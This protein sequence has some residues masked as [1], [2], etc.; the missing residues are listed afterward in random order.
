[1]LPRDEDDPE[2]VIGLVGPIGCNIH[3]VQHEILIVLRSLDYDCHVV[4]LSQG[5][6]DLLEKR[7]ESAII[8]TL[9]QKIEGGNN[10]RKLYDRNEVLA[11]WAMTKIHYFRKHLLET[12]SKASGRVAY[13]VRQLKRTEEIN[14]MMKVYGNRF[15]VVSIVESTS[16]R[17]NNLR[18]LLYR[19]NI[20]QSPYQVT[21]EAQELMK[22]DEDEED[23]E[24][25]QRLID[26]FHFGDVFIDAR[27]NEAIEQSTKR[28]FQALFGKTDISPTR[29]EFGVYMAKSVSLRSADL[30]RQ[31]GAAIFSPDGNIV[32][33]GCNENP[34][35]FGGTYW[36]EDDPKHRDI[37]RG[38]E[39][40]RIE[41]ARIVYDFL[42]VLHKDKLFREGFSPDSILQNKTYRHNIENSLIGEITEYGRMVHAEMNALAD[43][44]RLG[45]SVCGA[46][47]YVTTFPCH[48]CAKHIIASG[49]SRVVYIE[50]YPKSRTS[51][52]YEYA[53]DSN[54]GSRDRVLFE[55]FSGI[56]PNRFFD[57]FNK[58]ERVDRETR[59][60][61]EY[62]QNCRTP[63]I[64]RTE[65]DYTVR[66]VFAIYQN[67]GAEELPE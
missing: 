29:D 21:Q 6:S 14:L 5:I 24:N 25:G 35:P 19:E 23:N 26:I 8:D 11:A 36:D 61:F 4:E 18:E 65:G 20:G 56:A 45:R 1:M 51:L 28:F 27:K 60:V 10:V 59:E 12:Q 54:Q 38:S 16:Q 66:E 13:I 67:F 50:P 62:Y 40:N 3:K 30:S 47:M 2:L 53:I 37:D 44:A 64:G 49:I 31:V 22:R 42:G 33:I 9:K 34:K 58:G 43:A 41:K 63:R 17:E 7:N 32:A 15:I 48:N 55:P 52:L 39:A 46:T 57:I